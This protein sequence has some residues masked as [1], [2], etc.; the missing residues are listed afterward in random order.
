MVRL[1]QDRS[2]FEKTTSGVTSFISWIYL[3]IVLFIVTLFNLKKESNKM[4]KEELDS[5]TKPCIFY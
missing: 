1:S 3:A 5:L 2:I 4:K